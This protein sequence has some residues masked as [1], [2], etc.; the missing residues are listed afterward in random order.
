M[1][2]APRGNGMFVLMTDAAD[3]GIG[4][5]LMQE[6]Q[7]EIVLLEFAA[8]KFTAA[9]LNWDTRDREGFAIRWA[10][11]KF[12]MFVTTGK[13]IVLT[14]HENLTWMTSIASGRVRRWIVYLSQFDMEIRHFSGEGNVIADWLSRCSLPPDD[15]EEEDLSVSSIPSFLLVQ[16]VEATGR[17]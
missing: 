3:H 8:R 17:N 12:E 2:S 16:D 14:D 4:A 6:Q 15:F 11:A 13:L 7:G 5:V 10:V 9:E 1:L